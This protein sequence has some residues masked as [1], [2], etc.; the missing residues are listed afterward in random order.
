MDRKRIEKSFLVPLSEIEA[1]DWDLSVSR[2]KE[3]EYEEVKYDTPLDIIKE[4]ESIDIERTSFLRDL[5]EA[6]K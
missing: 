4:I 3:I 2:Y 1:N 6:L 5:R